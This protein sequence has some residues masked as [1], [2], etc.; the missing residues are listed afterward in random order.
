M[1]SFSALVDALL[2]E[3]LA[4]LAALDPAAA[5]AR[6]TRM[7]ASPEDF[8]RGALALH[9]RLA[10]RELGAGGPWV[11][12]NGD[13]HVG[14]FATLANGPRR[15]DEPQPVVYD[16][17]DG[18][19]EHPLPWAWDLARLLASL[20]VTR[21]GLDRADLRRLST[22]ALTRYRQVLGRAAEDDA[23]HGGRIFLQDLPPPL[24]ALVD[25]DAEAATA[26]AW[27][28]E[29]ATL[30]RRPA[31]RRDAQQVDAPEAESI[32][33][34]LAAWGGAPGPLEPLDVVRRVGS[35]VASLGRG[36][37]RVLIADGDGWRM[38]ELKERRPSEVASVVIGQ[39][40]APHA[41][42][43]GHTVHLGRD[44]WHA[45]LP[46]APWPLLVR[47]RDHARSALPLDG[48]D[49]DDLR[50]I[51]SLWATLLA[52][53]HLAGTRPLVADLRAHAAAI[54]DDAGARERALA[55]AS[56]RIAEAMR[57]AHQR[58]RSR[59]RG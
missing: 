26:T 57:T 30:G 31:L 8:Q 35:G 1:P 56:W 43:A 5:E 42:L 29:R 23:E 9:L 15:A 27:W 52:N 22:H 11:W 55:D 19:D 24:V 21:A 17:A 16:L 4:G 14:N 44:Q 34:A 59:T 51:V 2:V 33:A 10:Q 41:A 47:T 12:G 58:F 3:P 40:F 39:P 45:V 49:D 32:R 7:R 37:W 46:A 20:A 18:D 54:A 6:R 38:L 53:F 48:L 36:R 50:T 28:R 25:H 13:P